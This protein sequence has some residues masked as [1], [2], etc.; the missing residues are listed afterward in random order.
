MLFVMD[1]ESKFLWGFALVFVCNMLFMAFFSL[2][3]IQTICEIVWH[4]LQS[5][6]YRGFNIIIGFENVWDYKLHLLGGSDLPFIAGN[7]LDLESY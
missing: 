2:P 4:R 6:M 1:L 3:M 5:R 7:A